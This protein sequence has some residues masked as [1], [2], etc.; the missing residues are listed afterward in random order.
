MTWVIAP[1]CPASPLGISIGN[2]TGRRLDAY[3]KPNPQQ[4]LAE[5]KWWKRAVQI[6]AGRHMKKHAASV[7]A[8]LHVYL[9]SSVFDPVQ[10]NN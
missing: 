8:H 2:E 7:I 3:G 4:R 1:P 6:I 9:V 10:M 5:E